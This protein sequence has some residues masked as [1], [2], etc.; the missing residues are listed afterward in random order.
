[1]EQGAGGREPAF[2]KPT[3][4]RAWGKGWI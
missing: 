2:G 1:M 4:D 3:A